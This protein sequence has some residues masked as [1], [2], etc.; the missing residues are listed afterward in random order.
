MSNYEHE[1]NM[2]GSHLRTLHVNESF[3]YNVVC[4]LMVNYIVE[5]RDNIGLLAIHTHTH[6]HICLCIVASGA[7]N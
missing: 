6:T 5:Y 1:N 7:K 4:I 3:N 2:N